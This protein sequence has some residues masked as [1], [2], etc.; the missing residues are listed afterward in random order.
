MKIITIFFTLILSNSINAKEISLLNFNILCDFCFKDN[1][2]AYDTRSPKI[3]NLIKKHKADLISLQ[4]VRTANQAKSLISK[5]YEVIYYENWLLSYAD[6]TI[7]YKKSRFEFISKG[8]FW[9]GPKKKFSFGWKF[10]TPRLALWVKLKDKKTNKKFIFLSSHFD[11]LNKNLL[12]SAVKINSFIKKQKIPVIFSADT[13]LPL[14]DEKYFALKQNDLINSF[15]LKT[16]FK[17]INQKKY[18][19]LDLC[20]LH[21]GKKFPECRVEHIFFSNNYRWKVSD[22][23]IDLTRTSVNDRFLSDHRPVIVKFELL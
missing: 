15:D 11:N 5:E 17:V 9:L 2:D 3:K 7:A 14:S 22:W 23:I 6:P 8:Y 1:F 16:S 19:D 13:N 18:N 20:Y 4:E 12:G 10:S 21:K